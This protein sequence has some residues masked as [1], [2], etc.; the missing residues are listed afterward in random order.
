MSR[1]AFSSKLE[2]FSCDGCKPTNVT[3]TQTSF[4][5]LNQLPYTFHNDS[6]TFGFYV[7]TN[8]TLNPVACSGIGGTV[9]KLWVGKTTYTWEVC[10]VPGG[11]V[12]MRHCI[13]QSLQKM[14]T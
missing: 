1:V 6:G 9:K 11:N 8:V 13:S 12:V 4:D 5:A 2:F 10:V 7:T 14:K 3:L